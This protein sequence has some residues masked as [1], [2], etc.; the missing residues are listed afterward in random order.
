MSSRQ[1]I[2][3]QGVSAGLLPIAQRSPAHAFPVHVPAPDDGGP[4]DTC[5]TCGTPI[6]QGDSG[7]W[8]ATVSYSAECVPARSGA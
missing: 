8:R 7:A 4:Y 3:D 2:T 6:R 5:R 1:A